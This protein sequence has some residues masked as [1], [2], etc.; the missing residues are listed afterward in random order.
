MTATRRL[1]PGTVLRPRAILFDMDGT[2]VDSTVV[3]VQAWTKWAAKFGVSVEDIL[4]VSHGR[5][6]IETLREFCPPGVDPEA[7][8]DFLNREEVENT[9]GVVAVPGAASLLAALPPERWGMVT[10]ADV[11]LA[12]ARM[13]AAGLPLPLA[14]G[15]VTAELVTEGKPHP[16]GYRLGAARMGVAPADALVFEDAHAGI[17]AGQAAGCPVIALTTTFA[18]EE[19]NG[20]DW[21]PDLS[22]LAFEGVDGDG[23][24]VL[25]VRG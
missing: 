21:L 4:K 15:F 13:R 19:L 23:R 17:E 9:E 18:P 22:K 7:E 3:V 24:L 16:E 1:A 20:V 25:S 6:S 14:N 11:P 10:S 5:R 12:S 2:L 8:A